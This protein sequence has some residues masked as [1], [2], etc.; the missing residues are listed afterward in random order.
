MAGFYPIYCACQGIGR[1]ERK[2]ASGVW[3]ALC[4]TVDADLSC[5][6]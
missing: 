3:T 6:P 2:V 5:F 4:V 1:V